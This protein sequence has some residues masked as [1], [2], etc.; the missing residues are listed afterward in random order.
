[1]LIDRTAIH[2]NIDPKLLE[3]DIKYCQDVYMEPLIGT[4]MLNK[5][6]G[7]I[8]AGVWTGS[9]NYKA[10]LDNYLVDCLIWFTLSE[11]K[12]TM[13]VQLSNKGMI[14]KQGDNTQLP[15][16][17]EIF[18]LASQNKKRG[19]FY[20]ERAKKYMQQNAPAMFPEYLNPGSGIDDV[21]PKRQQYSCPIALSDT[22]YYRRGLSY[23]DLYQGNN[24]F[25]P[26]NIL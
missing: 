26:D 25:W 23:E 11:S 1:M 24:P 9:E 16:M 2:G 7:C 6:Q 13:S 18:T 4:G 8:V 14:R 15:S 12:T 3:S 17:D 10:L 21:Y 19:E 22:D 20:A 5:I